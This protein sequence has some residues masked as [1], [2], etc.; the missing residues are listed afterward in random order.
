MFAYHNHSSAWS[1]KSKSV[2]IVISEIGHSLQF[3]PSAGKSTVLVLYGFKWST[4]E[5]D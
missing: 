3:Q 5:D 1:P 2:A 4:H